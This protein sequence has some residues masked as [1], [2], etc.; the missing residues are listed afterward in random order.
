MSSSK[1]S[2]QDSGLTLIE[3]LAAMA[4]LA[5]LLAPLVGLGVTGLKAF[6]TQL[7]YTEAHQDS[8]VVLD[9]IT[10]KIR[11]AQNVEL[12]SNPRETGGFMLRLTLPGNVEECYFKYSEGTDLWVVRNGGTPS[13]ML[14]DLKP[15]DL[16]EY[17]F[18][19]ESKRT[20][21]SASARSIAKGEFVEIALSVSPREQS[22][23]VSYESRTAVFPRNI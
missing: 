23:G 16:F 13:Q 17:S 21:P 9:I 14:S 10:A 2:K 7:A 5:L 22:G 3:L 11:Q 19:R 18:V 4:I 20:L 15:A 6:T 1:K 12:L 8:R